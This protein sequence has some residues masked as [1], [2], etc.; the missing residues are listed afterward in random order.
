MVVLAKT[1]QRLVFW[2]LHKM[3]L[4]YFVSPV[5]A[6]VAEL[7]DACGSGPHGVTLGGSNPLVSTSGSPFLSWRASYPKQILSS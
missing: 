3:V 7:A 2:C 1:A 6:H 4:R 5:R